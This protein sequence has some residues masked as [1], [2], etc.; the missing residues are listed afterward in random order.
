MS[1]R[2]EALLKV[3]NLDHFEWLSL[4]ALWSAAKSPFNVQ[5]ERWQEHQD[6]T[7]PAGVLGLVVGGNLQRAK[8]DIQSAEVL[9]ITTS[10]R[11][12]LYGRAAGHIGKMAGGLI[13]TTVLFLTPPEQWDLSI[14]EHLPVCLEATDAVLTEV[15]NSNLHSIDADDYYTRLEEVHDTVIGM[16]NKID[17]KKLKDQAHDM[18]NIASMATRSWI[19]FMADNPELLIEPGATP[20]ST[21]QYIENLRSDFE[22]YVPLVREAA[23]SR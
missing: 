14:S 4:E 11:L 15:S 21:G 9:G 2:R 19:K 23:N 10:D 6:I 7:D 20:R 13:C 8:L 12:E 17:N 18:A 5:W 22:S 3:A 1:S 16:G